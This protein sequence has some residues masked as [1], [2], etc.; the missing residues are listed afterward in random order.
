MPLRILTWLRQRGPR[1]L[2]ELLVL[3]L[4]LLALE[5]FLT[6]DAPRGP[7]PA[8]ELQTIQGEQFSLQQW[9]GQ[10]GVLHF[11]ATWC[12]ICELE[13]GMIHRLAQRYPVMTVAMQS[14]SSDE[15]TEYLRAQGVDYG[16][17]NDPDGLL[18]SH[19]GV[20]AVPASFVIDPQGEIRFV[21]RGYTSGLGLR[22]RLWLAG[23]F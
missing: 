13:Q 21:T 4:V 14:G 15:V 3:A 2:V 10:A 5:R 9:Q 8:F 16:V 1:L 11:W 12:A 19:Y 20:R 18:A 23:I 7:A 6:R 22:V 17:I